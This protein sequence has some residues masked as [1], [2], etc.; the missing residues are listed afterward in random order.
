MKI[1]NT[2]FQK[3]FNI[4]HTKNH[5]KI[6]INFFINYTFLLILIYKFVDK[7]TRS[8]YTIQNKL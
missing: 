6:F 4:A 8:L 7:H 1:K 2:L 3:Y 5:I